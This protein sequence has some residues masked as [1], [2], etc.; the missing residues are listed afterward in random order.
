[1]TETPTAP[2]PVL[3]DVDTGVDDALALLYAVASPGLDL[4]AVTCVGGNTGLDAVVA[5]TRAVLAAAGASHVPVNVGHAHPEAGPVPGADDYHGLDGMLGCRPATTGPPPHP[6]H[7]VDA[8]RE[9]ALVSREPLTLVPLGPQTN[10]ADLV[11]RHPEAWV[12]LGTVH[13]MGGSGVGG[14][15][16]AAAEFN[17]YS[18]PEAAAT[19]LA[20]AATAGVQVRMYGLEVFEQVRLG[21]AGVQRLLDGAHPA[22]RLAGALCA[23]SAGRGGSPDACL[24]DAGAVAAL[25]RPDLLQAVPR[26]VAV[27]L[28]DGPARG[29]TVVDRRRSG[30]DGLQQGSRVEVFEQVDGTAL[31]AHWLDTLLTA[32]A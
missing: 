26:H 11:R 27:Q 4:R 24:G 8:L 7:A 9:H 19:V 21:P 28:G 32:Y 18:D 17:V 16:T 1:M 3:L 29:A 14:N 2:L 6:Q 20:G 15:V 30:R 31:A 10:I 5:N 12:G 13:F 25:V 22:A 23:A